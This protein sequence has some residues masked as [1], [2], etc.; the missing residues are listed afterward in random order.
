[1]KDVAT[2]GGGHLRSSAGSTRGPNVP[3]VTGDQH[4]GGPIIVICSSLVNTLPSAAPEPMTA[5]WPAHCSIRSI[6]W[7]GRQAG[8]VLDGAKF[9]L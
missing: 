7:H 8:G 5:Y 2:P 9:C 4:D 3:T 6:K 1:M